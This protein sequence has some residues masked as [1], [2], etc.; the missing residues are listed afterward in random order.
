MTRHSK[1]STKLSKASKLLQATLLRSLAAVLRQTRQVLQLA[2]ALRLVMVSKDRIMV[3]AVVAKERARA[4][5]RLQRK[6]FRLVTKSS[7][8]AAALISVAS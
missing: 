2:T 7:S 8:R 4:R 5:T 3:M 1:L 6:L